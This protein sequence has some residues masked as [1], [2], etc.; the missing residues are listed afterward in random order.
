MH[1]MEGASG[2]ELTSKAVSRAAAS[3]SQASRGPVWPRS[4]C[5]VQAALRPFCRRLA[6]CTGLPPSTGGGHQAAGEQR[7]A[8]RRPGAGRPDPASTSAACPPPLTFNRLPLR[9]EFLEV[10]INVL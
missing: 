4:T 2:R 1:T 5:P 6:L 3:W 7:E 9:L 10:K 8:A